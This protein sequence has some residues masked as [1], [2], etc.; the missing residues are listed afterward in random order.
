MT[1]NK[2][3]ERKMIMEYEM[4]EI[5]ELLLNGDIMRDD[6]TVN[7]IMKDQVLSNKSQEISIE[8]SLTFK[9]Y[10]IAVYSLITAISID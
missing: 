2:D 5:Q 4:P 8:V 6:R 9:S 10:H 1:N 7:D 3:L